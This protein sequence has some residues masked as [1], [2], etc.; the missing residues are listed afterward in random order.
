M[1]KSEIMLMCCTAAFLTGCVPRIEVAAPKEPITINMNV[2][3]EHE[4]HIK[5]DKNAT[6][7]LERSDNAAGDEIKKSAPE[8]AQ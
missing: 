6:Q 3:I 1:N 2:K 4:I 5:A 7:L 8:G